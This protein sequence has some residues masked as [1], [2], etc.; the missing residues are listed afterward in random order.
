MAEAKFIL[1]DIGGYTSFLTDVGLKHGREITETLLN[2]LVKRVRDR[3]K[4][5]NV[6]GD[7]IFFYATREEPAAQTFDQIRSLY[8]EFRDGV[9]DIANFSTCQCGAC[10]RTEN[11]T[12]KFVASAGEYETQ[13]I[14]GRTELIGRDIVRASRLLKNSVPVKEYALLT[15]EIADVAAASGFSA[16]TCHDEY[17][18]IGRIEY[19]YVDL[20]PVRE[21]YEEA[22]MFFIGTDDARLAVECDINAPA[23]VVW[24]AMRDLDKRAVWQVTI[25][26]MAHLQ[27]PENNV[28]EIHSC[29]HGS[30]KIIHATIALDHEGRRKTE[31]IW[32]T[33]ALMKDAYSTLVATP[34]SSDRTRAAMYA[35]YKPAIPVVSHVIAP[36]FKRVM[37]TMTNKDMNGLK[38]FCETGT[39]AGHK[40]AII[41]T[42]A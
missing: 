35:T 2:R 18:D 14:G 20:Q 15:P 31:R 26:Q 12:L 23:D 25:Q 24:A 34:I 10:N 13:N 42:P 40:P 32:I 7:C 29:A 30:Q 41:Q 28:G 39:V 38:E 36:Y 22:R 16:T 11:L 27:G 9:L 3:W 37:K 19:T 33:P 21:A 17:E 5:A 8:E 4:V 6:M 1:A